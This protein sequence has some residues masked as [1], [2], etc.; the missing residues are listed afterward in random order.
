MT[1]VIRVPRSTGAYQKTLSAGTN[2]SITDEDNVITISATGGEGSFQFPVGAIYLEVTGANPN[3]TFGYGTW[4]QIAQGQML[5]GQKST[6][7]NFDTAEETGGAKTVDLSHTHT[8]TSNVS[9]G[10]HGTLAHS[11]ITGTKHWDESGA[12]SSYDAHTV[13]AHSV[14]NN[15]VTSGSGGSATQSIMNPYFVVYIWKRTA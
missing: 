3:T 14:T 8:V 1:P 13:D 4:S 2:V 12:D 5:I 11:K 9:V 6:D 10:N 7:A 15:A